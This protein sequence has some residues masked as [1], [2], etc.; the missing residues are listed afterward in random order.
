MSPKRPSTT[1]ETMLATGKTK[2]QNAITKL[3]NDCKNEKDDN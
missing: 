2:F 3:T 1:S